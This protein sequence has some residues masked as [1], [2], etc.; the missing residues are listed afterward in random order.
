MHLLDLKERNFCIELP[1]QTGA[2]KEFAV[3]VWH[4]GVAVFHHLVTLLLGQ[5]QHAEEQVVDVA[6]AVY[7]VLIK[8]AVSFGIV[9]T[10]EVD[11]LRL[12]QLDEQQSVDPRQHQLEG[13]IVTLFVRQLPM[14]TQPC[15]GT[16]QQRPLLAS[17]LSNAPYSGIAIAHDLF[18]SYDVKQLLIKVVVHVVGITTVLPHKEVG[19]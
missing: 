11:D 9:P 16:F 12:H 10:I 8:E 18:K 5:G 1:L 15:H 17:F 4:V 7:F 14:G 2:L 19:R 6:E 13:Y 3:Q